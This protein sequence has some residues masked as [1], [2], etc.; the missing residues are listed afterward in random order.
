[1]QTSIPRLL[2][3]AILPALIGWIA[4]EAVLI[5]CFWLGLAFHQKTPQLLCE[6][7]PY[8]T[9]TSVPHSIDKTGYR[10]HNA[11]GLRGPDFP[12][13]KPRNTI[14]IACLGGS[15]TYSPGATS[16]TRTYPAHL[17]RF[18]RE[19]YAGRPFTIEGINAGLPGYTSLDSLILFQTL[20]LDFEPD[21]AIFHCGIND[22][23]NAIYYANFESDYSHSCKTMP[24]MTPQL[25]EH[26]PLLTLVLAKRTTPGNPY[27]P[28]DWFD[29]LRLTHHPFRVPKRDEAFWLARGAELTAAFERNMIS[30]IAVARANGI[31]PVLST[32][33]YVPEKTYYPAFVNACN[34]RVRAI[35]RA[36]SLTLVDYGR[37]APWNDVDFFD[38]CHEV[39]APGAGLER[40]GR[41]FADALIRAGI[42]D[43]AWR[44]ATTSGTVHQ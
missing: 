22:S 9:Y 34:E 24:P 13:A 39:D 10:S 18:L 1:L 19:H 26:S 17:E 29:T 11:Y 25:W 14:R 15:T 6:P 36:Q 33:S 20:V 7:H 4:C 40:K 31:I 3:F 5:S 35:A 37:E 16:D 8:R 21:V 2:L 27:R 30:L 28:A 42:I 44:N 32:M 41:I 43:Q 12:A 23:F 38:L